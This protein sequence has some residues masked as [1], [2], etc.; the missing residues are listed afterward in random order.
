MRV[1]PQGGK[2]LRGNK[3]NVVVAD[4]KIVIGP[5]IDGIGFGRRVGR[6]TVG[7]LRIEVPE[8]GV[9]RLEWFGKVVE[10]SER[11]GIAGQLR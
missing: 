5:R 4:L 8:I 2:P 3:R 1:L 6:R 7:T 10:G 9:G 11:I